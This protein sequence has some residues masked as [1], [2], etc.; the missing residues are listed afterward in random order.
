MKRLPPAGTVFS[1]VD[2]LWKPLMAEG[3]LAAWEYQGRY[4]DLGTVS[5]LEA[6]EA[7]L[8]GSR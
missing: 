3:K 2:A 7:A 4:F 5:D 1:V 8:A 6:A